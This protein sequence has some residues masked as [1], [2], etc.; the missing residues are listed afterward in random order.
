MGKPK[1]KFFP[2]SVRKTEVVDK[3]TN[4]SRIE[5]QE[6]DLKIRSDRNYWLNVVPGLVNSG[7]YSKETMVEKKWIVV[8]EKGETVI[9][10]N[11][12]S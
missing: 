7:T 10:T 1:K 12:Y 4:V 5:N 9:N 3:Y 6:K 8:N 11:G 2:V